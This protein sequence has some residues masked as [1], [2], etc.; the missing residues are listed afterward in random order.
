MRKSRGGLEHF[1]CIGA[2]HVLF[3][4]KIHEKT[5]WW[6]SGVWPQI[7]KS[8][9]K[10]N[11]ESRHI[12]PSKLCKLMFLCSHQIVQFSISHNFD[13]LIKL[14]IPKLTWVNFVKPHFLQKVKLNVFE[15]IPGQRFLSIMESIWTYFIKI[16]WN[17]CLRRYFEIIK[18]TKF[19]AMYYS[20]TPASNEFLLLYC[21]CFTMALSTENEKSNNDCKN[22]FHSINAQPK[23]RRYLSCRMAV[24]CTL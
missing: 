23:V 15:K 5:V 22:S 13:V 9:L 3:H 7:L 10:K 8:G 1:T 20:I 14:I 16:V 17:F 4:V 18:F 11:R 2:K 24:A 19:S 6:K 21:D 12:E